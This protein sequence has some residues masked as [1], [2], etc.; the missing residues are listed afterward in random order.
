MPRGPVDLLFYLPSPTPFSVQL[1]GGRREVEGTSDGRSKNLGNRLYIGVS[2]VTREVS[3]K[4]VSQTP[5][6]S[7]P[8]VKCPVWSE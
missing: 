2:E 5:S 3:M 6:M 8:W 4:N 1:T 7:L